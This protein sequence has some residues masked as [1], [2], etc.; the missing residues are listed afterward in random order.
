M[1][2]RVVIRFVAFLLILLSTGCEVKIPEGVI[3]PA[4][5]E[6]LLY[7][8]HLAQSMS[9]E[10]IGAEHKKKLYSEYVLEKHGYTVEQFDSSM[11]W[12]SRY[13]RY[14]YDIYA[15]LHKRLDAEVQSMSDETE[16]VAEKIL[17]DIDVQGDTVNLWR[18]N[19]TQL[20]SATPFGNR[21]L[22]HCEADTTFEQGDSIAFDFNVGFANAG[23]TTVLQQAYMAMVVEYDDSTYA[24]NG[25]SF[26]KSGHRS[27]SVN[28]N[29]DSN[30][31]DIRAFVYYTDNDTL[32]RSRMLL[33][34]I[35]ILRMHPLEDEFGEE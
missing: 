14:L 15:S 27:L 2:G 20:L 30:I 34:E 22:F 7:D 25:C 1:F 6:P 19:K 13:P 10:V 35:K 26:S 24:A 29:F 17:A 3:K 12:Y 32:L 9:K 31:K 23:D 8:Y 18:G 28:R 4:D 11:V 21:F 5:M 16:G 33:S